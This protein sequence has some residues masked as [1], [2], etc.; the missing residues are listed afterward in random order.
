MKKL[1]FI[2]LKTNEREGLSTGLCDYSKKH[3]PSKWNN[4]INR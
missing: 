1:V 2:K 4:K 3:P